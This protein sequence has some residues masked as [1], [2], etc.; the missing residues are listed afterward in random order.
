MRAAPG[1]WFEALPVGQPFDVIVSNPPYVADESPDLEPAVREWE[2][3]VALFGGRDGLDAVRVL[4]GGA[5]EHLRPGGSLVLEVGADQGP[6]VL[7]LL[8]SGGLVDVAVLPD[9]TG[10]DRVA[11]GR[12]PSH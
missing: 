5:L 12:A 2:P 9:L 11:V 1:S 8:A 4:A 10:R 6:A 3:S 7:E